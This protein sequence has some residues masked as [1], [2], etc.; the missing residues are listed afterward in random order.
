MSRL[1]RRSNLN[2]LL[3][4]FFADDGQKLFRDGFVHEQS[5]HRVANGGALHFRVHRDF[6]GHFQIGVGIHKNVADAFVMF[7]DGN[8]AALGHGANQGFRRRAACTDQRIA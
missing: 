3:K 5:L 8:F 6:F 2:V 4:K 1:G 7:D